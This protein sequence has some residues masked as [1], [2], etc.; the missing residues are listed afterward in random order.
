MG[1]SKASEMNVRCTMFD[2][3]GINLFLQVAS[4]TSYIVPH[5]SLGITKDRIFNERSAQSYR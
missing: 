1:K 2:V 4:P 3:R 5:K